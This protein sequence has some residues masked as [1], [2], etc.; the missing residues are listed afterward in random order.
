MC[1][2]MNAIV[3]SRG[4]L[5]LAGLL[6]GVFFSSD[7]AAQGTGIIT[8]Q[9]RNLLSC[10]ERPGCVR[11]LHGFCS[12]FGGLTLRRGPRANENEGA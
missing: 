9:I 10:S 4:L 7:A 5:A 2:L 1:K 3:C 8:V 12:V 11:L 6:P